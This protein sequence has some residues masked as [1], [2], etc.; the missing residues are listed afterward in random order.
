MCCLGDTSRPP[1][2]DAPAHA[3]GGQTGV[4]SASPAPGSQPSPACTGLVHCSSGHTFLLLCPRL[5]VLVSMFHIQVFPSNSYRSLAICSRFTGA[6]GG[7]T[8]RAVWRGGPWWQR[9]RRRTM[10][11]GGHLNVR[12]HGALLPAW[13]PRPEPPPPPPRPV[14]LG[15]VALVCGILEGEQKKGVGKRAGGVSPTPS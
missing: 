13:P 6:A 1:C 14:C 5:Q 4:H 9:P 2:R 10:W 8:G 12:A 15:G 7:P 3:P 11:P